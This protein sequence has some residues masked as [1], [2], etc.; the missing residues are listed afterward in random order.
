MRIAL[1]LIFLFS[2][3]C[4]SADDSSRHT[5]KIHF[6]YGSKPAKGFKQSE[7]KLFGGLK[8]GHVNI[9]AGGRVLDFVPG[10]NPLFPKN[11]RPS[12]GF[13]LN[14]SIYWNTTDKWLTVI[15]PVTRQQ[16][17]HL[18]ELFDSLS[19]KTPYDYAI[20]GMRCAAASYDVLT[21]I[22]LFKE[23]P[24]SK[25]ISKHFYPKLLRKKIVTW[26]GKNN[27]TILRNEGRESRKWESDKGIF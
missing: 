24:D 16:Y 26:A 1:V 9:E 2:I 22:G 21:M 17:D 13:R 7:S 8:G 19:S 5:I 6:L 23:I 10:N 4:V 20:F 14:Q 15:V 18:Q 3:T 27:Y 11:K 12:G 25:N